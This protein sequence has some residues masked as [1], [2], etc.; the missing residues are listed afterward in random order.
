AEHGEGQSDYDDESNPVA[1]HGTLLDEPIREL[2]PSSPSVPGPGPAPF[3]IVA[4]YGTEVGKYIVERYCST[5][6]QRRISPRPGR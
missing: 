6:S 3:R 4:T 1:L 5:L 2:D